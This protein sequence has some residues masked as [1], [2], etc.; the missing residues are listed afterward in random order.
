MAI[1]MILTTKMYY[2]LVLLC[3]ILLLTAIVLVWYARR[4]YQKNDNTDTGREP[5]KNLEKKLMSR[6]LTYSIRQLA[7]H[8]NVPLVAN[9]V[10]L[11]IAQAIRDNAEPEKMLALFIT[12]HIGKVNQ[13]VSP[14][15]PHVL[16]NLI[17]KNLALLLWQDENKDVLTHWREA[18]PNTPDY[19]WH[20]L[21]KKT[22]LPIKILVKEAISFER[23]EPRSDMRIA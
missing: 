15:P 20:E 22:P 3:L 8:S 10:V 7:R 21:Q 14:Y 11:A 16:Y 18:N 9:E 5:D 19:I 1:L 17:V 6:P 12:M 13:Y 4:Y 2:A 23:S